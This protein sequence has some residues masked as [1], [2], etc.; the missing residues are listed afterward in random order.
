MIKK[1]IYDEIFN[2]LKTNILDQDKATTTSS[3]NTFFENKNVRKVKMY[4]QTPSQQLSNKILCPYPM[5]T[6]KVLFHFLH[7]YQVPIFTC[8]KSN[9]RY[10]D[11]MLILPQIFEDI[12]SIRK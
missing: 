1:G 6:L 11:D 5:K 8:E 9:N 2:I 3:I 7:P 10:N 4:N 12:G